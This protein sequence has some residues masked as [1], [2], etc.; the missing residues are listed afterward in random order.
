MGSSEESPTRTYLSWPIWLFVV[1]CFLMNL[2]VLPWAWKHGSYR[3]GEPFVIGFIGGECCFVV[4]VS[5]LMGRTWL[6]GFL[7]GTIVLEAGWAAYTFGL[8]LV[9]EGWIEFVIPFLLPPYLLIAATTLLLLRQI[10][11]WRLVDRRRDAPI[12]QLVTTASLFSLIAVFAFTIMLSRAPMIILEAES[13]QYWGDLGAVAVI[14]FGVGLLALPLSAMFMLAPKMRIAAAFAL[15]LLTIGVLIGGTLLMQVVYAWS[16]GWRWEWNF[17]ELPEILIASGVAT[18]VYSAS[19]WVLA[20]SGLTLVRV[21]P[22]LRDDIA[23]PDAA[24]PSQRVMWAQVLAMIAVTTAVSTYLHQLESSRAAKDQANAVIAELAEQLGGEVS[25]YDRHI[26]W[27]RFSDASDDDLARFAAAYRDVL[28]L[29]L[30]GAKIT[31]AGLAHVA[32]FQRL[33]ELELKNTSVTDAGLKHLRDLHTLDVLGLEG[34][35]VTGVGLADLT[36]NN[37]VTKLDLDRCPVSDTGCRAIARFP[38][39]IWLYL[40]GTPITDEGLASVGAMRHI[41]ELD[42]GDTNVTDRGLKALVQ[43]PDLRTLDL[44]GTA[45]DGSGLPERWD[46]GSLN[47]DRTEVTDDTVATLRQYGLRSLSVSQTVITDAACEH[48][49]KMT[50][51]DTLDLSETSVTDVGLATLSDHPSLRHLDLS[52]TAVTGAGFFARKGALRQLD[53]SNTRVDSPGLA[54]MCKASSLDELYLAETKI[55]DEDLKLLAGTTVYLLDLSNTSISAGGLIDAGFNSQYTMLRVAPGQ[56]SDAELAR[57]RSNIRVE[58][59]VVKLEE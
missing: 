31:D 33:N 19:L 57:I 24:P 29:E 34:S 39:L 41:E 36:C 25:I 30:S 50:S 5:A 2:F 8:W 52:S 1:A 6:S 23:Q 59:E 55:T 14:P 46:L 37:S 58:V 3:V 21:K 32:T 20:A 53:L 22:R 49:R 27:A 28:Y 40:R 12:S 4:L 56:F 7:V 9:V 51:L 43:L 13:S 35:A 48:L 45:I 10:R 15:F 44:R 16:R 26:R 11:G 38:K 18:T 42:L 47:L 17:V 54:A